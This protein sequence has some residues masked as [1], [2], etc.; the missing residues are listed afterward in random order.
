MSLFNHLPQ[1]WTDGAIRYLEGLRNGLNEPYPFAEDV[2]ATTPYEVIHEEGKVRLRYYRSAAS[3]QST[4]LLIVYAL[5]KRPYILDLLPGKSVVQNLLDQGIDV[6]LTDWIPPTRADSWRGFDAYVN[7]DVANAV[8]AV[9]IH[10]GVE[11]VPLL[12]YCFGGLLTTLYTALH[13]ETVENLITLTLPLDMSAR[14]I[15]LF[16]LLDKLRPETLERL[17]A[18]YGNCPAWFMKT[19]FTAMS[20]VHHAVDKYVGLHRNQDKEGY[21]EMFS[22]FERW[23]N[24][25]VPLAGRI[26]REVTQDVF[27]QNLVVQN[28]L[29]VGT[30][31]VDLRRISCPVLNVVGE[32]DDVVHPKSSLPFTTLVGSDDAHNF[33]FPT[34]HVGA[35]VSSAAHK[36][37]WPQV[38]QW[39]KDHSSQVSAQQ[40]PWSSDTYAH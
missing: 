34:G 6:Y 18:T 40:M 37:L 35:V 9:Q 31:V 29:R 26:F 5:I 36:K 20:P 16:G 1:Y 19:A 4:P 10:A 2:P 21:A 38:G 8:R 7:G 25:D 24:S 23:M 12:G 32:Y 13:P 14:E 22:R 15:P 28:R 33:V 39:L 11:Q 3:S 17:A 30:E 27:R